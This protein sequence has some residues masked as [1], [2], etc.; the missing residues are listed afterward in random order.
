MST[1]KVPKRNAGGRNQQIIKRAK[2]WVDPLVGL[3][4]KSF[5]KHIRQRDE[6]LFGSSDPKK[7]RARKRML[8]VGGMV[9]ADRAVI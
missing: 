8:F 1:R 6:E 2:K 5:L 4:S 3:G 7:R 9:N